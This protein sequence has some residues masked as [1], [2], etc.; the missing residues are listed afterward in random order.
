M[1]NVT[2]NPVFTTTGEG[3]QMANGGPMYSG[4]DLL[5]LNGQ[6]DLSSIITGPNGAYVKYITVTTYDGF[7]SETYPFQIVAIGCGPSGAGMRLYLDFI[8]ESGETASLSLASTSEES[9]FVKCK[10][11]GL[12]SFNWHTTMTDRTEASS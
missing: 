10:T 5:E 9:H 11:D 4:P 6:T 2:S 1:S 3:S 7:M 12:I 8:N